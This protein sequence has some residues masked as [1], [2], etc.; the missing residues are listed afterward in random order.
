MSANTFG[1]Y[2]QIHSFGESHGT[3]LGC[4]IEGCPAGVPFDME[5]LT[6]EL[7]RRRPGQDL[8][9]QRKESD[10]P[11]VLS[12]VFEGKTLGTPIAITVR[13][14]D[15]KSQDYAEIQKTPRAGHADDM[16]LDKYGHRDH[17]GGGRSS[18]RETVARVMGGAVAKMLLQKLH[19]ELKIVG[20]ATEIGHEKLSSTDKQAFLEKAK[21]KKYHQDEF[22]ARFPSPAHEKIKGLLEKTQADGNSLGGTAEIRVF[23]MPRGL[24]QPVFHKLKADLAAAM[25]SVGATHSFSVGE[26]VD[27]GKAGV[28][29]HG[30]ANQAQYGGIRGGISTG[31]D[32]ILNVGFKPTSSILDVAKKGRHDPCIIPRALPVLESMVALVL[33]DHLLAQRLDRV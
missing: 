31:E 1:Q 33:A 3:A 16:W 2:F 10:L 29:F 15:A 26:D 22:T 11:E 28:D 4:V 20:F 13:N 23:N 8:T 9:S 30:Q 19:P 32:L 25:M 21:L 27:S 12:G 6:H 18:G 17:R 24:G 5:L 7:E 14:Q